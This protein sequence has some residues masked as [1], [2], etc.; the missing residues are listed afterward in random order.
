MDKQKKP[1][2]SKTKKKAE[3]AE[4]VPIKE[5]SPDII[6]MLEDLLE[7]AHQGDITAIRCLVDVNREPQ[8]CSVGDLEQPLQSLG[9]L[10]MM[11]TSIVDEIYLMAAEGGEE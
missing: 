11:K 8:Y 1:S 2:K 4:V 10:E 5:P 6:A 9:V 7:L 3:L